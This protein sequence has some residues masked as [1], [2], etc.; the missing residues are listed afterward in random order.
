MTMK[1]HREILRHS[2]ELDLSGN[3]IHG[4]LKVSRGTVQDCIRRAR[5]A[6]LTWEKVESLSDDALFAVLFPEK[7]AK[8]L[9]D[10]EVDFE[11]ILAE[12]KR[13]GVKLTLLYEEQVES[14]GLNLSYS[15]FCRRFRKWSKSNDIS[16]RQEHNAGECLFIDFCGM[17]VNITNPE[18]GEVCP[19]QIFVATF[20]ASNYTYFEGVQSQKLQDWIETHIRAFKFFGGLPKF[21]VPDNLKSAVTDAEQY[22]PILNRTYQRFAAHYKV[23]VKPARP[24]RPKDKA[25][26]E[27]GVQN[28]EYRALAKI[29]DRT[30]FSL[31]ELNRELALLRDEINNA[32]FQKLS[33]SRN[34][35][36]DDVE[37]PALRPLPLLD[38]EFE[39]WITGYRVPKDYHV[40]VHGHFYSVPFALVHQVVD[41]RYTKYIVEIL[42]GNTRAASHVRSWAEGQKT[43]AP[44]HLA[45][46]H[47]VY[48]NMSPDYFLEIAAKIG[49]STKIVV[50]TLLDSKPYPQLSYSECFGITKTLKA[51]YG[52]EALEL[53]CSHAI[54][55]ESIGYRVV[56]SLLQSDVHDL[57]EQ[58]SIRLGNKQH[59]NLR[60]ADYYH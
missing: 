11:R 10:I 48:H 16:M 12:L 44:E 2:L 41:I 9:V 43:T 17:T 56:K 3:A 7:K 4:I 47:A 54:R 38:F 36:F 14:R 23:G 28:T 42:R 37:K 1:T 31:K 58:L 21:L 24:S 46:S 18:T 13:R 51:A 45:P 39:N 55:L 15:Q 35:W 27:K 25:K 22:D 30:F 20:G 57:P 6:G 5:A 49:P 26:V 29:R 59:K 8:E 50:R 52:E 32:P 19:A 53:A 40:N 34:S 60:G 33:G